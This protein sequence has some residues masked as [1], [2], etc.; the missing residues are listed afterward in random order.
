MAG[1]SIGKE[2]VVTSFG[3]SHGKQVGV[4]V[5]GCPAGL[6]FSETD[7][8]ADLDRR[9][10]LQKPELVSGRVEKDSVQVISGVFNGLTTGAPIALAVENRETRSSDYD[11]IRNLPRPA[12]AD[13]PATVKYG[14]FHDYRGGGRFS[15]RL[16]VATIMAGAVAKK[17]L[18]YFGVDVLAY[19]KSI[20]KTQTDN[21]LSPQGIRQRTY[22]SAVRCPDLACAKKMEDAILDARKAGDS[23]GGVVECVALNVPVG[24]GEPLFDALDADLAKALFSIP[25]VKGVEFGAGF[26][27]TKMRGSEAND[28]YQIVEGKVVTV[29][30][31]A[32]GILG[33]IS[34]GMPITLRV[35]V[36]PTPSIVKEQQTVDL[37]KMENAKIK[38][39]GRHDPCVV[40]KAVP[41]VEAT[42]A[43]TLADHMIRAG[44]IP[45]VLKRKK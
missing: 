18:G 1:N 22:L 16:T 6:P 15:G 20:G 39:G 5:D 14:G 19:T 31:L 13:Y 42:V 43:V 21:P 7:V 23:L 34:S 17:L 12:H 26:G 30:N 33:G 25:A 24:V 28:A 3:E 10:P 29:T 35:A 37:S 2:F 44:F 41:A 4:V 11:S 38:V 45:K 27:L 32:G 8:Q 9:I 36:K 40:P